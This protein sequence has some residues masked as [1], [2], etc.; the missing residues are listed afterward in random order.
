MPTSPPSSE[1]SPPSANLKAQGLT[2]TETL[3]SFMNDT[4]S[5]S[6][7]TGTAWPLNRMPLKTIGSVDVTIT[8]PSSASW[9]TDGVAT[10]GSGDQCTGGFAIVVGDVGRTTSMDGMV[11]GFVLLGEV[12][13]SVCPPVDLCASM[14]WGAALRSFMKREA[15]LS[16]CTPSASGGAAQT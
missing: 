10:D 2:P 7:E 1:P 4:T 5:S 9:C 8:E 13:L 3:V 16:A 6:H 12:A 11:A 14:A 15:A